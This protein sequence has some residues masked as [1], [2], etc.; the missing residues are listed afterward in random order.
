MIRQKIQ[1][2]MC[3]CGNGVGTSLIMQMTIE[4]ALEY[5][6]MSDIEVVFGSLSEISA[7]RAD[8]FI[9]SQELL[10]SLGDLPAVGLEDLMDSEMAAEQ[11][12]PLLGIE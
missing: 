6:G 4:E 1:K 2:I 9:V 8:L 3:C 12:K 10:G 5:L 7:D 11:L